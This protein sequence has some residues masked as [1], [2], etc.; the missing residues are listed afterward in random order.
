MYENKL[1]LFFFSKDISESLWE[2]LKDAGKAQTSH[3]YSDRPW[4]VDGG[5]LLCSKGELEFEN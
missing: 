3:L 2:Y 4:P 5:K 1:C